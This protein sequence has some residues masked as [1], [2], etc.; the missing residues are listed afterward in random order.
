MN[1]KSTT[2]NFEHALTSIT[3][4]YLPATNTKPVRIKATCNA[5][6]VTISRPCLDMTDL[7][8]HHRAASALIEKFKLDWTIN[9]A[10]WL[11]GGVGAVFTLSR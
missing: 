4:K 6:S 3:T 10:A 9:D 8:M 11:P 2:S 1:T 5:G 7:Q